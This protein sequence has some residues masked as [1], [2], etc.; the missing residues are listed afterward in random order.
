MY[1]VEVPANIL[2]VVKLQYIS[3]SNQHDVHCKLIQ[4]YRSVISQE[5]WEKKRLQH[6]TNRSL[7]KQSQRKWQ[8]KRKEIIKGIIEYSRHRTS[9]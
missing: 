6:L 9:D 1:M 3:V 5:S 2:V 8:R 7:R 4:C